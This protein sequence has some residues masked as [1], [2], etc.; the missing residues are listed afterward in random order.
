MP[1][2]PRPEGAR[3]ETEN[4]SEEGGASRPQ[5]AAR[6]SDTV[7]FVA[8][9][10]LAEAAGVMLFHAGTDPPRS[11]AGKEQVRIAERASPSQDTGER[12]GRTGQQQRVTKFCRESS[13]SAGRLLRAA[14]CR[15]PQLRTVL[16]EFGLFSLQ[17]LPRTA[18]AS[19][20]YKDAVSASRSF[21]LCSP[22]FAAEPR[23]MV[24]KSSVG[25]TDS[26]AFFQACEPFPPTAS[27]G[28][29]WLFQGRDAS[30]G[31]RPVHAAAMP[32]QTAERVATRRW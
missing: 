8:R 31:G 1:P 24:S 5:R 26:S 20:L 27:R 7:G 23:S 30:R 19:T 14:L 11:E 3:A 21:S 28:L 25:S 10:V 12:A 29:P 2:S 18:R 32:A 4:A 17:N 6:T 22:P 16:L 9:A 13:R 15:P